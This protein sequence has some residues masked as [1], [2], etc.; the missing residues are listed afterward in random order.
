[1]ISNYE[2]QALK[3]EVCFKKNTGVTYSDALGKLNKIKQDN[4]EVFFLSCLLGGLDIQT[5]GESDLTDE[6]QAE[7]R[8]SLSI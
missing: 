3:E 6:E 4:E 8:V 2:Q 1:M 5:G 7:I